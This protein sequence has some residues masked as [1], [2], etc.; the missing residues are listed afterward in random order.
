[1][2]YTSSITL[3][4]KSTLD[5]FQKSNPIQSNRLWSAHGCGVNV[6]LFLS[7]SFYCISINTAEYYYRIIYIYYIISIQILYNETLD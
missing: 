4:P 5:I 6:T 1:M 2:I 3:K 7:L